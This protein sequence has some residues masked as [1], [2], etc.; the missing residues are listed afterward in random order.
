MDSSEEVKNPRNPPTATI[1]HIEKN[2]EN[3]Q[4][5]TFLLRLKQPETKPTTSIQTTQNN[6]PLNIKPY[7]RTIKSWN[8]MVM[9]AVMRRVDGRLSCPCS[10][11]PTHTPDVGG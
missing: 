11:H 2:C 7:P 3:L 6:R 10:T 8:R 5:P 9:R 1:E 4:L